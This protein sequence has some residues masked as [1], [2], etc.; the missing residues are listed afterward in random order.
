MYRIT[1]PNG[2]TAITEKPTFIRKHSNNCFVLCQREKAEGVA[3]KGSPFMFSDGANV[4][5]IDGG[6]LVD[7]QQTAIDGII[8]TILEG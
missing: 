8:K 4:Q 7:G 2:E 1:F 3:Y 5:E 6:S